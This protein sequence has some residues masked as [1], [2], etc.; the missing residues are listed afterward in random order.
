VNRWGA[1]GMFGLLLLMSIGIELSIRRE[2]LASNRRIEQAIQDGKVVEIRISSTRC[3]RI[4]EGDDEGSDFHFDIGD[5]RT[6]LVRDY[7][8]S[9]RN[10]PSSE[11]TL[12]RV[13]RSDGEV[14]EEW[15]VCRGDR[16]TPTPIIPRDEVPDDRDSEELVPIPGTLEDRLREIG[17]ERGWE[18]IHS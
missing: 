5:Q 11:L 2:I 18:S 8:I 15:F 10:F 17:A 4:P 6:V 12:T 3:F 13:L 7:A 16:L 1:L 14:Q 9:S